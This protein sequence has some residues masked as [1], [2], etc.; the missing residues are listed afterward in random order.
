MVCSPLDSDYCVRIVAQ[1]HE[2]R[3]RARKERLE[4]DVACLKADKENEEA[5]EAK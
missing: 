3:E 1:A 2:A 5:L 4:A